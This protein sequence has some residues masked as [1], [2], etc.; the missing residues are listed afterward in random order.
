MIA[1]IA[2]YTA[3]DLVSRA[4]VAREWR[5]LIWLSAA[6]VAMG[7]G[8]W[9][10]HFIGMLAFHLP[11]MQIGYDL[12]ITLVSLIV[13]IIVTGLAFT[14]LRREGA[15]RLTL[16]VCG[17]VTGASIVTMHYLGMSA[18]RMAEAIRYEPF[19]T[20][21]SVLIA[22]GASTLA[23]W[24][25]FRRVGV[26]ERA[27]AGLAMGLAVAGMHYAAMA[28]ARF[29]LA[30]GSMNHT[31]EG[32]LDQTALA[33][34]VAVATF[35]IL[36]LALAA[37]MFDRRFALAAAREAETLKHSED[38][39][40]LLLRSVTDY[41]IFMLDAQGNV[42]SW[43]AGAERIKGYSDEE[44]I[45]AHMS[46]FYT[47]EDREAGRPEE[48]LRTAAETGKF[49][50]EAW[51]VRKDGSVFWANV[52]IDPIRDEAGDLVGFAK[53]TRDVT[54]RKHTQEAL[55]V[56]QEAL[57]QARKMEALG[58]LTGGVAHDF[59][60]LL[61]IVMGSM[62]LLKKRLSDDEKSRRLVDNAY[63][64]AQRG[65][66]LTQR[67]LAF[68]RKQELKPAVVQIS[69]LVHGM[70]DLLRRTLDPSVQITFE[71]PVEL[72]PALVDPNQLELAVLNLCVNSRD[73]MPNGGSIVISARC[74]KDPPSGKI[75]VVVSVSDDGQGM[76]KATLER[77]REPFFTT[78]A[79]GKGTGLGLSMIHGLAEQSGGRLILSSVEC[80]GATA[81]LWL[82]SASEKQPD[83]G[84]PLSR[85]SSTP[86]RPLDVLAVDDDLLVLQST[87]AMLQ[88]LGH[89]VRSASSPEAAIELIE[90]LGNAIDVLVTD[91]AM[92]NLTGVELIGRSRARRPELK[93]LLVSGY[94]QSAAV[95]L[96]AVEKLDKPFTQADLESS[97][98]RALLV[99]NNADLSVHEA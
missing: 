74:E 58:Q 5:A 20:I 81:E 37:A 80:H 40:R 31:H 97:L 24:L 6:A 85:P 42:A 55:Q 38:K 75:F 22:V 14:L 77:A 12:S 3:L 66:L 51:R 76:N 90:D 79:V 48:A 27:G 92:P 25:A 16:A 19:W 61:M 99:Q 91:Q 86:N 30:S 49:E 54:E 72:P 73:A 41:A 56:A 21:V 17:V 67:M 93:A 45:G 95:A 70:A 8:I 7:G 2:S 39:F 26:L 4:Q 59:N 34:A 52:V 23:L 84:L 44:I 65:A 69:E 11:G 94:A 82:P 10:M 64:A 18:M 9:S 36:V 57:A 89:R 96:A 35:L 32:G 53:I 63:Q 43:N 78:K 88:D 46:R 71:I 87:V 13:P 1:T 47:D 33:L 62:E 83:I 15:G 68:A 28:G 50:A 60:N 29:D 98:A